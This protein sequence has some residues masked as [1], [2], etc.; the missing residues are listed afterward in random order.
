MNKSFLSILSI[1]FL[2]SLLIGQGVVLDEKF[3]DWTALPANN[4]AGDVANGGLDIQ[5]VKISNDDQNLYALITLSR[6]I[7][8]Q[9]NN[10]IGMYIDIDNISGTGLSINGIGAD[11]YYEFGERQGRGYYNGSQSIPVY[12]DEIGLITLP[13]VTSKTFE[14]A[15]KR[16]SKVFNYNFNMAST[17]KVVIYN[18]DTNDRAP[19]TGAYTYTFDNSVK[20]FTSPF[21]FSK[22]SND[23]RFLSYNVLRDNLF[24]P[25]LQPSF[26]RIFTAIK[27]DVVGLCEIYDNNA[28]KVGQ[29]LE[30]VMPSAAGQK[31]YTDEVNPDIRLASRY[32]IL[33]RV[34][35][36]GNGVFVIDIKGKKWLYVVA[37]LPCCDNEITRQREVDKIMGFIRDVRYGIASVNVPQNTPIVICGDMNLVGL[38]EQQQTFITG[39]I[40]N[41]GTYGPDFNPDWDE[42]NLEDAVPFTTN[43]AATYTWFSESGS[44][45]AGRL[46]YFFYTGSVMK[47][48]NSF[49]LMTRNLTT[50]QLSVTGLKTE[51]VLI[52]SDHL[53]LVA[54]FSLD[55]SSSTLAEHQKLDF[56]WTID[57]DVLTIYGMV[58]ADIRFYD[59]LG[60]SINV[61]VEQWDHNINISLAHLPSSAI[62]MANVR[63]DIGSKTIKIYKP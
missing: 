6:E 3:S 14:I 15:I 52:A 23:I 50:T 18:T 20:Q 26:K 36:D 43:Q 55:L 17:V 5:E 40:I 25:G 45:S 38:R 54:D 33:E 47:L 62:Y 32:P 24:D 49:A 19:S 61:N 60:K 21:S 11:L 34:A 31:W 53:P 4:D 8:I 51:D 10:G 39:N 58:D 2:S 63:S 41:N 12:H 28:V 48:T 27:P 46:D 30:S 59:I 42:S 57:N 9:A 7:N 1:T 37:H 29:F 16:S 35:L 22:Q 13:T 44:Y 56:P